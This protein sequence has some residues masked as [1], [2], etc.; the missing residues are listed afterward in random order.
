MRLIEVELGLG[1]GLDAKRATAYGDTVCT[2]TTVSSRRSKTVRLGDAWPRRRRSSSVDVDI[3]QYPVS[4]RMQD[5]DFL[6]RF[7]IEFLVFYV[8]SILRSVHA[9][10]KTG[11]N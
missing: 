4:F 8:F 7:S 1:L 11:N 5:T 6:Q 2:P 10:R 9:G 3:S